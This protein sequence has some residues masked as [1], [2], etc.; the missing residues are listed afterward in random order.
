[1]IMIQ[2]RVR[3]VS[4]AIDSQTEQNVSQYINIQRVKEAC[5][6]LKDT[7]MQVTQI[8]YAAGFNTKSNFNREFARIESMSPSEWRHRIN[9]EL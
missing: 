3:D 1:M 7:N 2:P 4:R 6:L 9:K 5:Q 8:I